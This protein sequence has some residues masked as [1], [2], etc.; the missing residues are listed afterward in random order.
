MTLCLDENKRAKGDEISF[1]L[2]HLQDNEKE[3][4]QQTL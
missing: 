1:D 3:T 2:S 4:L